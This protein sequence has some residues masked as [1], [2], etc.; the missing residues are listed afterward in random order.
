MKEILLNGN[1]GKLISYFNGPDCINH[2]ALSGNKPGALI[3]WEK[4]G[5]IIK[6]DKIHRILGEGNFVLTVSEG[7]LNGAPAAFYDLFRIANGKVAEHWDIIE[8]IKT[9]DNYKNTNGK[10]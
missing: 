7:H 10:F 1:T 9:K 3:K 5:T 8:E 6:Y 2:S 4:L